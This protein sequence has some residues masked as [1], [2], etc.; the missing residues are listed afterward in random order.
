[1]IPKTDDE[2]PEVDVQEGDD[3]SDGEENIDVFD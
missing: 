2:I 3:D 1:M